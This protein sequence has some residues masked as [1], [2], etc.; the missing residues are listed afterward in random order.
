MVK[1]VKTTDQKKLTFI[2]HFFVPQKSN[3]FRPHAIRWQ[4]LTLTAIIS[5]LTHASYVYFTTGQVGVLGKSVNIDVK[6]LALETNKI[7]KK[8]N[9]NELIIDARLSSAAQKKADDMIK[10]NYWSHNSPTGASPWDFINNSGF[11]YISA[12]E[13]LAKNYPDI[14]SLISAWMSSETHRKNILNSDFNSVGFAIS[15]GVIDTKITTIIVAL[16]AQS[17][18][19]NTSIANERSVLGETRE[20]NINNP[21]TYIG[22]VIKNLS[23]ITIGT[24]AVLI[25]L[26]FVAVVS[27]FYREYIP[28]KIQKSWSRH[29]GLFKASVLIFMIFVIFITSTGSTI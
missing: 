4:S 21:L 8:N 9:L 23:P 11:S 1:K 28:K 12:G 17:S 25:G 27:H 19:Q 7:R 24:L 29:H 6:S 22:Y 2:K 14:E 10:N 3:G 5:L 16:Y 18:N 13:N 26:T 15:D 20:N